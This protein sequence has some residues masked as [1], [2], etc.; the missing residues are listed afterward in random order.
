MCFVL[1]SFSR[2]NH[3]SISSSISS[4]VHDLVYDLVSH[5]Y[6]SDTL[7][8]VPDE[9]IDGSVGEIDDPKGGMDD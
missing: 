3:N 4:L 8:T 1:N 7:F 6:V 5:P 9:G 2:C